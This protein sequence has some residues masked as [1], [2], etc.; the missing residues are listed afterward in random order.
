[1]T[2]AP[3]SKASWEIDESMNSLIANGD[4]GAIVV[5]I[6]NGGQYRID[7]LT[8]WTNPTYGGGDGDLYIDF[9]VQTLKPIVDANF[10]TLP[11]REHTA[12]IGSSSGGLVSMYA[13][14]EHQDIFGKAGI[15]SPSFWFSEDAYTH[16][17][18]TGKQDDMRIYLMAGEQESS[19]MIPNLTEMY[20][21]FISAGFQPNELSFATHWDGKHSEWYWRREFPWVY[22]W[23]FAN[24][25][26]SVEDESAKSVRVFPNPFAES[27]VIDLNGFESATQL[28]V[29]DASGRE[30]KN[31]AI[32]DN[33]ITI[34]KADFGRGV[35]LLYAE[36]EN[37]LRRFLE[38]LVVLQ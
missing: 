1:M 38:K 32:R 33:R 36:N 10:R 19:T 23:L 27:C 15:L 5:G 16:V 37:G 11:D 21:T 30:M 14:I 18:N 31:Y 28:F 8:P 7:E 24:T 12:I 17:L 2:Q 26:V 3:A 6:D 13:A 4:P 22:L 9:I 34:N 25:T 20:N 35:F 29:T